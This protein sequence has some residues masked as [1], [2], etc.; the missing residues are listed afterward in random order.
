[1]LGDAG[2]T[3]PHAAESRSR[4]PPAD[5]ESGSPTV[6]GSRSAE[7]A[8]HANISDPAVRSFWPERI[9]CSVGSPL[10]RSLPHRWHHSSATLQRASQTAVRSGAPCAPVRSILETSSALQGWLPV[11]PDKALLQQRTKPPQFVS[12][13]SATPPCLCSPLR[14]LE[15]SAS[16]Y[17]AQLSLYSWETTSGTELTIIPDG[18][19]SIRSGQHTSGKLRA[20][21]TSVLR[22]RYSRNVQN[23]RMDG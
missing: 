12:G 23:S 15:T 19:H 14:G 10:R 13:A 6:F 5:R 9:A 8:P 16:Q 21:I 17:P 20:A 3:G 2:A 18:V 4:T 7:S 22:A 11:L 1:M